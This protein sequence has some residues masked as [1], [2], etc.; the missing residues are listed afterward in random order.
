[1]EKD[2]DH[3]YKIMIVGNDGNMPHIKDIKRNNETCQ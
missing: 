3:L 1:M 2:D